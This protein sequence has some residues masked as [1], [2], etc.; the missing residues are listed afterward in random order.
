MLVQ[1]SADG[2]PVHKLRTWAAMA[3]SSAAAWAVGYQDLF[4]MLMAYIIIDF[5]AGRI[6][7][8]MPAGVAQ[9]AIGFGYSVMIL[10]HIGLA[11]ALLKGPVSTSS[12]DAFMTFAGWSQFAILL[13]WSGW[14]VGRA[15]V[16]CT[17]VHRLIHARSK[18]KGTRR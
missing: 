4:S 16:C 8:I 1:R 9:K 5:V 6:V 17:G 10:Y 7:L 13:V 11:L 14:D 18:A 15:I 12:Y 2:W 3:G